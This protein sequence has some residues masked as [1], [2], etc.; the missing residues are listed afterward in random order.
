MKEQNDTLGKFD[1]VE[2]ERL[3]SCNAFIRKCYETQDDSSPVRIELVS[4]CTPVLAVEFGRP[5]GVRLELS[6]IATCSA[7]TRKHVGYFL[8]DIW[9]FDG[10]YIPDTWTYRA[11][12]KALTVFKSNDTH[13]LPML[14]PNG[15]IESN[16]TGERDFMYIKYVPMKSFVNG[17]YEVKGRYK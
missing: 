4:Y 2:V 8:T 10:I 17:V 12:K 1:S 11:I 7:T 14:A 15:C 13:A 3:R 6:P 16:P 9:Y 5:R